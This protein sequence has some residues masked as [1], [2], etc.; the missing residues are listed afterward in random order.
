VKTCANASLTSLTGPVAGRKI[1]DAVI[2]TRICNIGF[3][4]GFHHLIAAGSLA[5]N[6]FAGTDPGCCLPFLSCWGQRSPRFPNARDL[7]YSSLVGEFTALPPGIWASPTLAE[8]DSCYGLERAKLQ[9][10]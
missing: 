4:S 1:S 5:Q 10:R 6:P 3:A 7:R 2:K 9:R 8:P